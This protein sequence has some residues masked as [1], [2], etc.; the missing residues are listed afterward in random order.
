MNYEEYE[1]NEL[2]YLICEEDE[3][4]KDILFHKYQYIIDIVIKKYALAAMKYGLEYKDLYQEALVGFS[5]ALNSYQETKNS[6]LATFITICVDRRLCSIL[7][8]SS[9]HKNIIFLESLSL[10]HVYEKYNIQ[11]KDIISDNNSHDP[12]SNITKEEAFDELLEDIKKALSS[13]EYEVYELLISGLD[14]TEIAKILHQ[15]AK[16]ID[17][18]I[19]RIKQ[20]IKDI[21]K[22]RENYWFFLNFM[23]NYS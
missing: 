8:K 7:K 4:A 2:Y 12:L 22:I 6:S 11:L 17:N 1:D 19:Q 18:A 10:E 21:L 14:Y 20:K 3:D 23:V 16:Q 15:N 5:D 9:R 13:K